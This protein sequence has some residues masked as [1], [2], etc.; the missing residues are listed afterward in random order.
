MEA[1]PVA[2]HYWVGVA[3]GCPFST[4]QMANTLAGL[5][6]VFLLI[7]VLGHDVIAISRPSA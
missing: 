4:I 6:L 7:D 1:H 5:V 3:S 2:R